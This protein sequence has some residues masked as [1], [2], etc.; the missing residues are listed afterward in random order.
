MNDN[1]MKLKLEFE[2]SKLLR[3]KLKSKLM[4]LNE[5][6]TKWAGKTVLRSVASARILR[7]L[8]G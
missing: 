4:K 8:T 7:G 5:E 3:T 1:V 2:R 6:V